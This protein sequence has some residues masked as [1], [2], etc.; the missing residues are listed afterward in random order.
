MCLTLSDVAE[1]QHVEE[2]PR[3][4][5]KAEALEN[6]V[7]G[8]DSAGFSVAIGN[9][10]FWLVPFALYFIPLASAGFTVFDNG[11]LT[12]DLERCFTLSLFI[13]ESITILTCC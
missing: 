1:K 5:N 9:G 7:N 8:K 12:D 4:P 6:L 3:D 13:S 10:I 2:E 11:L